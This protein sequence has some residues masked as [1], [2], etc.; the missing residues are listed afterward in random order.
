MRYPILCIPILS[1]TKANGSST[2]NSVYFT[3]PVKTNEIK[4]YK[5]VQITNEYIIPLGKSRCGF[6]HSSA[7]VEMASKPI[8]AKNTADTPANTPL[9]PLGINGVQ[10]AVST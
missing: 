5:T 8:N 7:V 3:I 4:I 9:K 2:F 1:N 6:L 10:F